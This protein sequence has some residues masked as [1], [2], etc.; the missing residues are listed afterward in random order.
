MSHAGPGPL[1]LLIVLGIDMPLCYVF[2]EVKQ[3][4]IWSLFLHLKSRFVASCAC[5]FISWVHD[6]DGARLSVS[7]HI[8]SRTSKEYW[9]S[10]CDMKD[11]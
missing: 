4:K 11:I 7:V 2:L 5:G 6:C 3:V 8:D 1:Y 9:L 10:L